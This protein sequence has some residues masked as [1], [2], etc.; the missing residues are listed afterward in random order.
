MY[1]KSSGA[2]LCGTVR[3]KSMARRWVGAV[4]IGDTECLKDREIRYSNHSGDNE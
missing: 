3:G 2:V 4:G 1:G